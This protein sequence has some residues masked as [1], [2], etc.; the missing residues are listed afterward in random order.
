MSRIVA[1]LS[2]ERVENSDRFGPVHVSCSEEGKMGIN[3]GENGRRAKN[4]LTEG[5][6]GKNT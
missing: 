2:K 1:L 6:T 5:E 4:F 3:C